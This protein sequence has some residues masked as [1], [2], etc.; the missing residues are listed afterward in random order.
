MGPNARADLA[1]KRAVGLT[2]SEAGVDVG[3]TLP[4]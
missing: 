2:E 3:A 1:V 4:R